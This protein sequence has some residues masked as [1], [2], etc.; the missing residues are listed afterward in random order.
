MELGFVGLG[1]M[2]QA[3]TIRLAS[4]GHRVVA[5]D[6]SPQA[7]AEVSSRGVEAAAGRQEAGRAAAPGPGSAVLAH[8]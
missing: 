2:G 6:I 4:L 5:Y 8:P 3:M 7:V 1:L